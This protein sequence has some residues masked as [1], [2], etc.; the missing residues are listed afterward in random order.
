MTKPLP[1]FEWLRDLAEKDPEALE[2]L[3]QQYID[4]TI[5]EAPEHMRHRL[6]GLQFQIDGQRRLAK[7]PMASCIAISKM[8]HDSLH[9]LKG[10]IDGL[11]EGDEQL[12]TAAEPA[13]VLAFNPRQAQA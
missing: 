4:E 3:R 13:T 11:E 9:Q 7:S 1:S 10:Y 2:R 12:A 6:K 8:M 5:S